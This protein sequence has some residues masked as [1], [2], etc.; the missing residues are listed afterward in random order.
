MTETP[1]CLCGCARHVRPPTAG[2]YNEMPR[3]LKGH[4]GR[5]KNW[6]LKRPPD[7]PIGICECGCGN[8]TPI[9]T[10]TRTERRQYIG[11][12]MPLIPG[13]RRPEPTCAIREL[14]RT[15]AAYLAGIVDG[16]GCIH[17][18]PLPNRSITVDV[19]NTSA[20]LIDWL[21][22]IGGTVRVNSHDRP[23]QTSQKPV[24]N[25]GV[26]SWRACR[27][28]LRQIEPYMIIKREKAR[29]AF[30]MLSVWLTDREAR[31]KTQPK[32]ATRAPKYA[33][34]E[35]RRIAARD[36]QRRVRQRQRHL[37]TAPT[38]SAKDSDGSGRSQVA[39]PC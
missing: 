36:S 10:L 20:E 6:S 11:H 29:T 7:A 3:Y 1:L 38:E 28:V 17:I 31:M 27:D 18:R 12:P 22:G 4:A 21:R 23:N 25:W 35:E 8:H 37:R 26:H 19:A 2:N 39:D 34:D 13:H 33:T 16:E 24:F 9:C 5:G 14:S 32:G 15:E 30:G